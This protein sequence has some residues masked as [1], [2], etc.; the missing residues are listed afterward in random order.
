[1]KDK[2]MSQAN[3]PRDTRDVENDPGAEPGL[4]GPVRDKAKL[5]DTQY[6]VTPPRSEVR[7]PQQSDAHVTCSACEAALDPTR[8]YR[9][10][11]QEYAY[12]FCDAQCFGRWRSDHDAH[13]SGVAPANQGKAPS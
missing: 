5:G 9:S 12:H 8:S 7:A 11:A 10:D 4:H 3:R 1:L 2:S 13:R 6:S